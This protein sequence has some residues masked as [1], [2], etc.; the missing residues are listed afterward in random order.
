MLHEVGTRLPYREARQQIPLLNTFWQRESD[1]GIVELL[2]QR[3]STIGSL[4]LFHL[5]DLDWMRSSSVPSPHVTVALGHC[6]GHA[7]VTI[8]SIHVVCARSW[9][10]TQPD[11]EVL[12]LDRRL[13]WNLDTKNEVLMQPFTLNQN[14]FCTCSSLQGL[15]GMSDH[16]QMCQDK[17]ATYFTAFTWNRVS[18]HSFAEQKSDTMP[19]LF[20]HFKL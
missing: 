3:T 4:H 17:A 7:Q 14:D 5:D 12:D 1:L 2:D 15:C 6:P 18:P 19:E 16:R 11:A 9:V 10:V 8:L 13:L 20:S